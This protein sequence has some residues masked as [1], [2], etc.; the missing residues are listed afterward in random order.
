MTNIFFLFSENETSD[1]EVLQAMSLTNSAYYII[2]LFSLFGNSVI[3]HIIR[4]DDSMK[5]TTNYLILNQACADLL[6]TLTQLINTLGHFG[7]IGNRWFGGHFGLFTCKSFLAIIFTLPIFSLWILVAIA[8]ER[9]YAVTRP[10]RSSPVSQH[11]KKTI[12]LLWVLSLAS[13]T[14]V[15]LKGILVKIKRHY[16]CNFQNGWIAFNGIY[17]TL[18]IALP[19]LFIT[20]L[21]TIV[22]YKLWSRE[23]P[24]EGTS[25]THMQAEALKTAR[26]VTRMM[27]VVVALY[28]LCWFPLFV[29]IIL[30]LVWHVQLQQSLLVLLIFLTI[31]YSALNPYIY[32]S[33]SQRFRR[34]FLVLFG[35]CFRKI[36][37][38]NVVLARS[39]SIELQQL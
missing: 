23:V 5:T 11:F 37:I 8:V 27:I 34:K 33:F 17:G 12:L 31:A 32:L 10:L 14:N 25:Q 36:K 4:T 9:F 18:N 30:H 39:Q 6:I 24:G 16:Y 15:I 1:A 20:A 3:I 2:F 22:C 38:R 35:N 13:S 19:L 29:S 26:K 21:Y 28:V 7:P